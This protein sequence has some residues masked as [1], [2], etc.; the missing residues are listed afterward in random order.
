MGQTESKSVAVAE[1][2]NSIVTDIVVSNEQKCIVDNKNIQ[3]MSISNIRVDGCS[4]KIGADQTIELNSEVNCIQKLTN[5]A[6]MSTD[7]ATQLDADINSK[8]EG[9]LGQTSA[10]NRTITKNL[11][12]IKNNVDISSISTCITESLNQQ[13]LEIK[14]I[15]VKCY[16]WQTPSER[17]VDMGNIKQKIIQNQVVSCMQDNTIVQDAAA[18]IDS[19]LKS[20]SKSKTS[21]G[22][23]A[24]GLGL[25][26]VGGTGSSSSSSLCLILIIALV[27]SMPPPKKK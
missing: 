20:K 12:I 19:V 27:M 8:V 2:I 7:F 22:K 14:K 1:V 26:G 5:N 17:L 16:S 9:G 15:Q 11:T 21:G 24:L 18:E 3:N 6:D 13:N 23:I 10:D 25:G 4:L